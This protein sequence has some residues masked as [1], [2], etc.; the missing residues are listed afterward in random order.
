MVVKEFTR[1]NDKLG[2]D[3]SIPMNGYYASYSVQFS[4]SAYG[5]ADRGKKDEKFLLS[6][7]KFYTDHSLP[8]TAAHFRKMNDKYTMQASKGIKAAFSVPDAIDE[9]RRISGYLMEIE[10][11][12][13][14][15]RKNED[16][17]EAAE[18]ELIESKDTIQGYHDSV[19]LTPHQVVDFP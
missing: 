17:L 8:A 7:I 3:Y 6:A 18:R 9:E 11:L 2:F 14:R 16:R 4:E 12:S 10:D 1:H 19:V 15:L 13:I 5:P